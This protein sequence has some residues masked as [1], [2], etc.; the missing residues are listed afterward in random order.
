MKCKSIGKL[1]TLE[2]P[3]GAGKS[4]QCVALVRWLREAGYDVVVTREPGGTE[5]GRRIR[6]ILLETE[7][8]IAFRAEILLYAADR[9]Q[10]VEKLIA[11]ALKK[12]QV[13]ICDRYFDSTMAYQGYGRGLGI[14]LV[15]Q[16][17]NLS[18]GKVIPDL[19]LL[20]DLPV[21]QGMARKNASD[22]DRMEKEALEF[23]RRVREGYLR[24]AQ[25]EPNRVKVIDATKDVDTVTLKTIEAV[26]ALLEARGRF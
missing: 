5:L 23:H 11:P 3:E 26:R 20:F 24:I 17:N 16:V 10:H 1:I 7:L 25:R 21:E 9:A 18:V 13:V 6:R 15:E 14:E 8:D 2:G 12:G 22:L 19:T 4:T